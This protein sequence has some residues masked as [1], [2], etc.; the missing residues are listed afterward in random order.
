MQQRVGYGIE[1]CISSAVGK[2]QYL[3]G[4]TARVGG[5]EE[6]LKGV[7]RELERGE[8]DSTVRVQVSCVSEMRRVDEVVLDAHVLSV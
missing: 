3:C 4:K 6:W 2:V 1:A 5:Q 8:K 7:Q